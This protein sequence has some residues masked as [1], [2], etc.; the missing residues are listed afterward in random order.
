MTESLNV[1]A[2]F[3]LFIIP[4]NVRAAQCKLQV[5]SMGVEQ[6]QNVPEQVTEI[7]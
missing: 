7:V 2:L 4:D 3:I 5:V 6:T 1:P